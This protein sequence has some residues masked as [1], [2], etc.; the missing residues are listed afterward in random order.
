MS[1][2]GFILAL[3]E[4]TDAL[5][6]LCLGRHHVVYRGSSLIRNRAPIGPYRRTMPRATLCPRALHGYLDYKKIRMTEV[7]L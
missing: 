1:S 2:A 4:I 6:V 5:H 3:G 7:P